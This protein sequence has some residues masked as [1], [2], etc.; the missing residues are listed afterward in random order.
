[1]NPTEKHA[2]LRRLM[3]AG[4]ATV[5]LLLMLPQAHAE[6]LPICNPLGASGPFPGITVVRRIPNYM[7]TGVMEWVP[8]GNQVQ[9][10]WYIEGVCKTLQQILNCLQHGGSTC[11]DDVRS[12]LY[13]I[14]IP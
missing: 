10:T 4:I 8:N 1:M 6:G 13:P 5:F 11:T 3:S 9:G 7:G 14:P 2:P 12:V